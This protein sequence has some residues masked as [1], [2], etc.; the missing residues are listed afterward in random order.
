M[1]T[2]QLTRRRVFWFSRA[3]RFQ[4]GKGR[5]GVPIANLSGGEK[6]R[7]QLLAM[8]SKRPNMILLDEPTNDLDVDT[9]EA[10][11]SMLSGFDGVVI[12]TGHDRSFIDNLATHIFVFEGGG[13]VRDWQGS[14]TD[15]RAVQRAQESAGPAASLASAKQ[16][17]PPAA[18]AASAQQQQQQQLQPQ[19]TAAAFAEERDAR[20]AAAAAAKKMER[21]EAKV[22]TLEATLAELDEALCA[23][24]SDT[25]KAAPLAVRRAKVAAE[26]EAAFAEYERLDAVSALAGT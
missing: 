19:Q 9:I 6:R 17:A 13:V 11:E 23:A 4:F 7:L 15:L 25:A 18:P 21:L 26:H 22:A 1:K 12:I 20:K 8:L 14:F 3:Q 16:S 2:H 5:Q 24:A 10:V